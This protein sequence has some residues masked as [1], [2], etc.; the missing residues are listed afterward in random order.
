MSKSRILF[1]LTVFVAAMLLTCSCEKLG[2]KVYYNTLFV[3]SMKEPAGYYYVKYIG[4]DKQSL[5][6]VDPDGYG[7]LWF[8]FF[9]PIEV[10]DSIYEEGYEYI[11]NVKLTYQRNGSKTVSLEGMVMKNKAETVINPDHVQYVVMCEVN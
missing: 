9:E 5:R 4:S 6:T 1:L 8:V 7:K 10:F 3:A 11:I 2:S